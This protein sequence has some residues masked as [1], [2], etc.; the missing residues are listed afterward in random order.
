[1]EETFYFYDLETSGFNPR[2]A[3]IM[4]FA[5]QRTDIAMRP[6]GDPDN[7]LIRLSE[8]VIPSPE[9]IFVTG[10]TPQK[11]ISEGITEAEFLHIFHRN[12]TIPGTIFVGYNSVRFDDEFMRFLHYRN[13]Y[14]PY[15]WEWQDNRSRWD[16][17]DVVRMTRALRPDGITW[18]FDTN[19]KPSNRLE[20]L[21][22]VNKIKHQAAHDAA[23]DVEAV[24]SVAR[25]INNKQPKLFKYLLDM[26]HKKKIAD[27][28][29]RDEPFIYT[30]GKYNSDYEKTTVVGLLAE[31][32]SQQGGALVFDLR[33]DPSAFIDMKSEELAEAMKRRTDEEGPRFPLKTLK[34]NRCPAIAPLN[35]LDKKSQSRLS[36]NISEAIINHQTLLSVRDQLE[37]NTKRALELLDVYQQAKFIEDNLDADGRLY[38]GFFSDSDKT[39][40]SL[41][42]ATD[43]SD[44]SSSDILFS[45]GRL[46]ALLPLYKA[47][48]FPKMLSDEERNLWDQYRTRRLLGN[49]TDSRIM[50]YFERI[51]QLSDDPNTTSEQQY[52]LEELK[53]YGESI[54]PSE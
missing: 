28:V 45:D 1:M 9:A 7:F 22:E 2:E 15:E 24:I 38:D 21:T 17:L 41:I 53:L 48:N 33:Y 30:S 3:R 27:L 13:F 16:I 18:P 37:V 20:L 23:S 43:P 4:Q 8:D 44:L 46:Q 47:R 10:I 52:I 40:M 12:I 25:L 32:P 29:L 35:V 5:G 14:D 19:G 11:T 31:H 42:R 54:M 39:K 6:I 51:K 26:R 36:I 49:G 50:K 34:Y